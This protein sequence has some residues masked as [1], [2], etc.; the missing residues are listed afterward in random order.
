MLV[1]CSQGVSRSVTL[2]VAY[3]MWKL[4]KGYYEVFETVKAVRGVASPNIGFSCQARAACSEPLSVPISRDASML[5][6]CRE[7]DCSGASRAR[8]AAVSVRSDCMTACSHA[9]LSVWSCE[10]QAPLES[11][12][13]KILKHQP[14]NRA[15]RPQLINWQKRRSSPP[16]PCRL[17][18]L[19]AHSA[20]APRYLVPKAVADAQRAAALDPRGAF[21]IQLPSETL[22]WQVRCGP[23]ACP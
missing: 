18:R 2:V 14:P 19:A 8:Q 10:R 22:V 21:V 17:F 20:G 9:V 4:G 11:L 6:L 23:D 3:L 5:S 16:A 1:H 15:A 7:A 13:R 12:D